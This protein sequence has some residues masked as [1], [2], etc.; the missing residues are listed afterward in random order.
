M[1]GNNACVVVR[2]EATFRQPR[3]D[4]LEFGP[5]MKRCSCSC[6]FLCRRSEL[7]CTLCRNVTLDSERPMVWHWYFCL[8]RVDAS[9]WASCHTGSIVWPLTEVRCEYCNILCCTT[10]SILHRTLDLPQNFLR[11]HRSMRFAKCTSSFVFRSLSYNSFTFY[12]CFIPKLEA[13]VTFPMLCL[14]PL[15]Q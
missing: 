10:T 6:L 14:M 5:W 4:P 1:A 11:W 7:R 15:S 3:A 12:F 2:L 8:F 9:V 13:C